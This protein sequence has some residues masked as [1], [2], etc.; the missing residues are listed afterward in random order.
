MSFIIVRNTLIVQKTFAV[1][2]AFACRLN[3]VNVEDLSFE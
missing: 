2:G 1:I 3:D